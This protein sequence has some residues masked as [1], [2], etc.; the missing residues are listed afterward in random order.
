VADAHLFEAESVHLVN[1]VAG[2]Y[3]FDLLGLGQSALVTVLETNE[4]YYVLFA[5]VKKGEC[6]DDA[7]RLYGD[8]VP[9]PGNVD[10]YISIIWA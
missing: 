6:P 4:P 7:L 3:H 8:A 10:A 5:A 9:P 2:R 1:D